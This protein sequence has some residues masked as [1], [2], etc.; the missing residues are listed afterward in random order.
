MKNPVHEKKKSSQWIPFNTN[1]FEFCNETFWKL[2]KKSKVGKKSKAI[3]QASDQV[4]GGV[5]K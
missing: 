2:R 4:I 1:K 5:S 3:K